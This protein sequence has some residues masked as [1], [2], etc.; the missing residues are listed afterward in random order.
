MTAGTGSPVLAA[1][2]VYTVARNGTV[3]AFDAATG[4]PCWTVDTGQEVI[5]SYDYFDTAGDGA[6]CE[7]VYA[8]AAVRPLVG[9]LPVWLRNGMSSS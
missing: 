4:E 6:Y 8:W 5:S 7:G 2:R 3:Q 1:G 9:S